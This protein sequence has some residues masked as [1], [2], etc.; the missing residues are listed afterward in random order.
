MPH[1]PSP[2]AKRVWQRMVQWYGAR[3]AEQYGD[4][5][6]ID[7]CRAVDG[8]DDTTVQRAL[9]LIKTRH[10]D[11]PPTLPQFEAVMRPTEAATRGPTQ[12]E[13]LVAYVMKSYGSRLTPKQIREPWDYAR[14]RDGEL[15]AIVP[16]DGD[17]ASVKVTTLEMRSGQQ[18]FA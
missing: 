15:V 17:S 5:P 7:W 16:A 10:L 8:A 12:N 9:S 1:S 6:P 11:H 14:D 13:Q 4:S 2:R 18:S 3:V